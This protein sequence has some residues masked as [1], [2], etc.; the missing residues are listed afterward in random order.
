MPAEN[1]EGIIWRANKAVLRVL[2]MELLS[3]PQKV[4]PTRWTHALLARHGNLLERLLA[5]RL[6]WL[7]MTDAT[8]FIGTFKPLQAKKSFVWDWQEHKMYLVSQK[9]FHSP[10]GAV[11]CPHSKPAI[12]RK[13]NHTW[14]KW[15]SFV[16]SWRCV[17]F[18]AR[19]R[20]QSALSPL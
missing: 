11:W 18:V 6:T 10:S 4:L 12:R 1:C 15:K 19:A 7:H 2:H 14:N 3:A 17:R 13:S 20:D 9:F 5:K 16:A 8:K